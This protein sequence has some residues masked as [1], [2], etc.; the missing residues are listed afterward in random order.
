MKY[1][2]Q[3]NITTFI[4]F[5]ILGISVIIKLSANRDVSVVNCVVSIMELPVDI[6][7]LA[8][9]FFSAIAISD[10]NGNGDYGVFCCLLTC[11]SLT[12]VVVLWRIT[13]K[14][15][16]LRL[17]LYMILLCCLNYA[18]SIRLL[19]HSINIL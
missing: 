8:F 6:T 7:V 16:D 11:A 3:D 2:V 10:T 4:P 5:V 13:Q 14:L 18:I 17:N 15:F 9:S 19:I 1:F 12:V